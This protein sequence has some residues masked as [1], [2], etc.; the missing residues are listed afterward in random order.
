MALLSKF[1][2]DTLGLSI[3]KATCYEV[4]HTWNPNCYGAIADTWCDGWIFALKTYLVLYGF[5]SIFLV[6]NVRKIRWCQIL[7]DSFRSS[8]FLMTNLIVFLWLMCQLRK[9]LGFFTIP[10]LGFMNGV[11]SS[12]LA[13]W[14]EN[15]RRRSL[16]ALHLTNLASETAYHQLVNHGYLKY[17]PN[18]S[19]IIFGIGLSG[20]LYFYH[21]DML[22]N[23]LSKAVE[24]TLLT[25]G[26]EELFSQQVIQRI[27]SP[28]GTAL[29]VLRHKFRKHRLCRHQYSCISR[30][31][32][33]FLKNFSR[34]LV[35]SV[36]LVI[37]N[38]V[39]QILGK[40]S[41]LFEHIFRFNTLRLPLFY[42]FL[43]LLFQ[44]SR[45]GY[46]W[47][48]NQAAPLPLC[49]ALSSLAFFLYPNISVAM[50][51][52]W[53]FVEV[54]FFSYCKKMVVPYGNIAL[55]ALSTGYIA[56]NATIEPQTLREGY[57]KFLVGLTGS[58]IN[59]LNR[60]LLDEFGYNSSRKFPNFVPRLDAR[61]TSLSNM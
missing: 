15:H 14:I 31:V 57:W 35:C 9:M 27:Y 49:G 23:N 19:I 10:T 38:G 52:F 40:P 12:L 18:G 44:T 25:N 13:I 39:K 16:L 54:V 1:L 5:S 58:R 32:E 37:F 22:Y 30:I 26:S 43:G 34:A 48:T 24:Y 47:F 4:V 7:F 61:F 53:K 59:L 41:M 42:G 36:C 51:V 8:C 29:L 33:V 21:K 20:L 50:Y 3:H 2:V 45:C 56:W 17:V 28:V 46:S 6:K 55:Y 60:Q 11:I